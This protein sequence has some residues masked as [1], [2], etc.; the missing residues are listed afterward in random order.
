MKKEYNTPEM[1][2]VQMVQ[3]INIMSDKGAG[4][5]SMTLTDDSW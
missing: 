1:D 5:D 3:E 2:V 4:A